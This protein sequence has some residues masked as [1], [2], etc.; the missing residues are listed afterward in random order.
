MTHDHVYTNE[1][2]EFRT[3]MNN[4]Y[5]SADTRPC[6]FWC[7]SHSAKEELHPLKRTRITTHALY[8]IVHKIY[9]WSADSLRKQIV[10]VI[11]IL[12]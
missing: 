9:I 8:V 4:K 2:V 1:K 5:W 3:D 10:M 7:H 11:I 12:K 6:M